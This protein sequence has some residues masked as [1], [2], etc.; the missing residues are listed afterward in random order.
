MGQDHRQNKKVVLVLHI[1]IGLAKV[2]LSFRIYK[3]LVSSRMVEAA[4][5]LSKAA[6]HVRRDLMGAM[7][8][9]SDYL[10]QFQVFRELLSVY[11]DYASWL[12]EIHFRQHLENAFGGATSAANAAVSFLR[13]TGEAVCSVWTNVTSWL[14]SMSR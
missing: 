8:K 9:A 5:I 6:R 13:R 11:M 12:E 1:P 3:S 4:K 2:F 7:A 14:G 10:S